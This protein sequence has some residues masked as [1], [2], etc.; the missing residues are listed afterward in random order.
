MAQLTRTIR[1]QVTNQIRDEVVAGKLPAGQPLREG[2][3]AERFGVSRGPIRDAF[4]QL[5]QEGFLAYQ[6]NRGV[7]VRKPPEQGHRELIVSLRQQ[8]ECFVIERGLEHLREDGLAP[9]KAALDELQT[10]CASSDLAAVA[11]CDMAFHEAV[12][13]GCGGDDLLPVWKWLCSQMLLTY[14]RLESYQQV[15]EEHLEILSA[16]ESGRKEA[17]IAVIKANI[18]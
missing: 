9:V 7:T 3:L 2:H 4:L 6:A 1:E 18:C 16:L 14:S 15:Y 11:R 12:L 8:I 5:S 13:L 17:A 10:A